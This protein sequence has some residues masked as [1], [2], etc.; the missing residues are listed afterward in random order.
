MAYIKVSLVA[1][2]FIFIDCISRTL[3][4]IGILRDNIYNSRKVVLSWLELTQSNVIGFLDQI[5]KLERCLLIRC[6]LNA[7]RKIN[8]ESTYAWLGGSS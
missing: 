7:Q 6:K 5:S 3:W 8:Y 4:T 1:D 2:T